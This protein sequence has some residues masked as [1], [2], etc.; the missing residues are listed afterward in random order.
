MQRTVFHRAVSLCLAAVMTLA[1][2]GT[3]DQLAKPD[4]AEAR[5]A[6]APGTRA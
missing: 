4:A 3:L 2:L 5:M 1:V 6:Q